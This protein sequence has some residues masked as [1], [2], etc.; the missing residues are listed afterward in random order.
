VSTKTRGRNKWLLIGVISTTLIISY[1]IS[2]LELRRRHRI[3]HFEWLGKGHEVIVVSPDLSTFYAMADSLYDPSLDNYDEVM[4][5]LM[6]SSVRRT[7]NLNLFYHPCRKLEELAWT[8]I[9]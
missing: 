5:D 4:D 3:V 8:I 7:K 2:Y 1:G 6:E 9:D